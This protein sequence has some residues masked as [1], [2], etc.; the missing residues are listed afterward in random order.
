MQCVKSQT[1]TQDELGRD[2]DV[3]NVKKRPS[4]MQ[5]KRLNAGDQK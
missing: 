3:L 1:W 5:C 2:R 4:R